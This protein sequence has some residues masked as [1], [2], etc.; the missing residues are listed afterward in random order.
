MFDKEVGRFLE[1]QVGEMTCRPM[2]K[3]TTSPVLGQI[4]T[5]GSAQTFC[6]K[7]R[8]RSKLLPKTT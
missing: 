6:D 2:S 1:A 8:I 5:V 7:D 4:P 3:R